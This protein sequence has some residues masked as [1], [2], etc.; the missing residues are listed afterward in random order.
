[1]RK[2]ASSSEE[3]PGTEATR[4]NTERKVFRGASLLFQLLRRRLAEGLSFPFLDRTLPALKFVRRHLLCYRG[5][6]LHR[7]LVALQFTLAC[8][9][10]SFHQILWHAVSFEITES[11]ID[12]R[13]PVAPVGRES[14]PFDC[15]GIIYF[16][17]F[18]R[19][20]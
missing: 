18:A 20:E 3:N 14:E 12:L 1:M 10:V 8:P 5:F 6:Q 2:S 19:I 17:R 7:A 16:S 15:F 4:H 13:V 11:E 9:F